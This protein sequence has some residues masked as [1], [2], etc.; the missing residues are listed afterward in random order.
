MV[1]KI[2]KISVIKVF[3]LLLI[4]VFISTGVLVNKSFSPSVALAVHGDFSTLS[5]TQSNL[6]SELVD[7]YLNI[8]ALLASDTIDGVKEEAQLMSDIAGTLKKSDITGVL[9]T[10]TDPVID[11][12]SGLQSGDIKNARSSFAGMSDAFVEYVK[13]FG[14]KDAKARDIKIKYCP[15]KKLSW[16]QM[17]QEV[18]NPFYGK[19]MLTCGSDVEY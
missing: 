19:M 3:P 10:M 15:M 9:K 4:L 16:L 11:A 13:G 8:Q 18:K 6:L 17:N 14:K 2:K 5:P 1:K 12:I 7:R